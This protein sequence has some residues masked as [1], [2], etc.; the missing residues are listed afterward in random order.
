MQRNNLSKK[1]IEKL[2][3]S[4]LKEDLYPSGDITSKLI[5]HNNFKSFKIISNQKG[6]LGGIDLAKCVFRLVDSKI[7]FKAKKKVLAPEPGS[8]FFKIFLKML[9]LLWAHVGSKMALRS[10]Q[11]D[12]QEHLFSSSFFA[13]FLVRLGSDFASSW[14]PFGRPNR[15]RRPSLLAL[16]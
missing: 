15:A 6:I 2:V 3:K 7:K 1:F 12:L 13:S 16:L 11:D 14:P 10:P 9:G 4:A 8:R 5:K